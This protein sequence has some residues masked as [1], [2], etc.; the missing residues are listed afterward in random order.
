[1]PTT[2]GVDNAHLGPLLGNLRIVQRQIRQLLLTIPPGQLA[3]LRS[4]DAAV[5]VKDHHVG[6]GA[7]VGR[8]E[9]G[10]GLSKGYKIAAMQRIAGAEEKTSTPVLLLHCNRKSGPPITVRDSHYSPQ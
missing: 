3:D 9:G 1:M 10:H 4:A 7:L 5:A 2:T 6:V 8:W